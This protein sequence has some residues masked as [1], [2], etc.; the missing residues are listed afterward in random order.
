MQ[1]N[2][3]LQIALLTTA[4][5]YV[6][7]QDIRTRKISPKLC[8]C[9]ALLSLLHF[10]IQNFLGLGIALVLWLIAVYVAPEK[11]GGG[12]IKLCVA[13]SIVIGFTATTYGII[14]AF[15]IM[16]FICFVMLFFKTKGEVATFSLPLAPFLAVG[17]LTT[18]FMKIGGFI[19]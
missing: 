8:I 3:I 10:E 16:S 1:V 11:L 13:I 17:F 12:D 9:I 18:Y 2:L 6:A 5:V 4:L 7:V 15:S 19:V 14:I